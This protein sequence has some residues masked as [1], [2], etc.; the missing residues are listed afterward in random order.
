MFSLCASTHRGEGF[1]LLF[2]YC[3][4]SLFQ[5]GLL[6]RNSTEL[7]IEQFT[8]KERVST[9]PRC[10]GSRCSNWEYGHF[11][12]T[13]TTVTVSIP[14]PPPSPPSTAAFMRINGKGLIY[15][16]RGLYVSVRNHTVPIGY[17][18]SSA[19]YFYINTHY[20][21]YGSSI[22]V[23]S[24]ARQSFEDSIFV[25][26][27]ESSPVCVPPHRG[28]VFSYPPRLDAFHHVCSTAFPRFTPKRIES[29]DASSSQQH[30]SGWVVKSR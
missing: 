7:L 18:C 28:E 25:M 9:A 8:S 12:L 4:T 16:L 2:H 29:I 10:V 20:L 14:S 15:P 6:V 13:T 22:M 11:Y 5:S 27:R 3:S 26:E 23:L 1:A 21:V 24:R 30:F 17:S 19:S